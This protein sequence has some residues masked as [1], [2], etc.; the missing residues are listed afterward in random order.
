M[1]LTVGNLHTQVTQATDS[2]VAWLRDKASGLTYG[3]RRAFFDKSADKKVRF[4][5]LIESHFPTGFLPLVAENARRAGFKVEVI[6]ARVPPGGAALPKDPA[7]MEAALRLNLGWLAD[8]DHQ[9]EAVAAALAAGRGIVQAATGAGKTEI[10][11]GLVQTVP[12]RW[13]FLVHRKTLMAQAADRY[14]LRTGLQAGRVGD[15]EWTTGDRLTVATFQTIASALRG[16]KRKRERALRFLEQF[17]GV[18]VDE[19]HVLP[20]ESFWRVAMALPNAHWRFGISATPLAREDPRS[21]FAV[22]ATGPVVYRV[23]AQRLIDEGWLAR[24]SIRLVRV[25]QDFRRR[26][27]D[28]WGLVKRW[29]WTKTYE[30]GVVRSLERNRALIAAVQR[31]EKPCL[32]FVKDIKHGKGFAASLRARG[33]SSD[34]VWGSASLGTRQAAV[35]RLER[36]DVEAL[37]SSVIFQEGVDIPTLR[38]VVVA[39]AGKSIIAALQRIGRGMRPA[40]GKDTFEVW[41]VADEGDAWLERHAKA[42]RRAYQRE[43][44][45]VTVVQLPP[46]MPPAGR[47]APADA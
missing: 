41:D 23:G 3:N 35:R 4:Y 20:A 21:V 26:Q 5:D 15:G 31:A 17:Q 10:A 46:S 11:I 42:R 38:S 27:V 2:E 19:V 29:P 1:W 13:L 14:Q 32:V 16:P 45:Q 44:H 18:V 28:Q 34:F 25:H 39:S 36:G 47:A 37:V 33:V 9:I 43:G 24:P 30:E 40:P 7:A 22:A 12:V 6:D 8:R